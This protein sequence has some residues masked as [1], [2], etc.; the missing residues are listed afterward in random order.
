MF[1]AARTV[2]KI[3]LDLELANLLGIPRKEASRITNAYI[4]I[5]SSHLASMHNVLLPGLGQ[6]RISLHQTTKN[7]LFNVGVNKV[8]VSF[9]KS[10]PLRTAHRRK[11][12]ELV[13]EKYGVDENV[14]Q[15]K[16]EKQAAQGCPNCGRKP[17]RHGA[18]LICP[19]CGSEPF[20]GGGNGQDKQGQ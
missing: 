1:P 6:F 19:S 7:N 10:D 9:S 15:E 5:L 16:L 12:K 20:E 4:A 17:I 11:S 13:M 14:N 18:V 8:R 2:T 3:D